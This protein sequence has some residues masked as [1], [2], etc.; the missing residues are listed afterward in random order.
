MRPAKVAVYQPPYVEPN[1]IDLRT[2]ERRGIY[3]DARR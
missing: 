3:C 1:R 2:T